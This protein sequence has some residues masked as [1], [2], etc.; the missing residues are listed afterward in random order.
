MSGGC[1]VQGRQEKGIEAVEFAM[2]DG[3]EGGQEVGSD[4]SRVVTGLGEGDRVGHLWGVIE[5]DQ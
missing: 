2:T 3:L 4:F 5:Q 1:D